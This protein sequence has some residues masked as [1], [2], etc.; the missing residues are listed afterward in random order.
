MAEDKIFSE[1]EHSK[2][3][4]NDEAIAPSAMN[5]FLNWGLVDNEAVMNNIIVLSHFAH[6]RVKDVEIFLDKENKEMTIHLFFGMFSYLLANKQKVRLKLQHLLAPVL[7]HYD[8]TV[9][10][11]WTH[12]RREN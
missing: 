11:R 4:Q 10:F 5:W 8:I 9:K 12:G 2:I 3:V 6:K 7:K 1:V